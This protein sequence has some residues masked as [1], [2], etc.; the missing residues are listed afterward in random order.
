MRRDV[1][2]K[3]PWRREFEVVEVSHWLQV[4]VSAL[5]L[6]KREIFPFFLKVEDKLPSD[7]YSLLLRLELCPLLLLVMQ[8]ARRHVGES[9]PSESPHSMSNEVCFTYFHSRNM[10]IKGCL[11]RFR[12]H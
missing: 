11:M 2:N 1:L 6:G 3:V 9:S 7:K 12:W 4:V 8:A 5:S 10:D